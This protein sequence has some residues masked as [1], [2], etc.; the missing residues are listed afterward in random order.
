LRNRATL[1]PHLEADRLENPK[2]R[3]RIELERC[4]GKESLIELDM[5]GSQSVLFP[6]S[7]K[8][9]S[10]ADCLARLYETEC[11]FLFSIS[12]GEQRRNFEDHAR[13]AKAVVNW[14]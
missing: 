10:T 6:A 8:V 11:S 2:S 7:L 9:V 4:R 12:Y 13:A 3:G 1:H 14:Q 5:L